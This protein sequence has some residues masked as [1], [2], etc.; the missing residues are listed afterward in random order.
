MYSCHAVM[1]L[2]AFRV[3]P[4]L[5]SVGGPHIWF[6]MYYNYFRGRLASVQY[7]YRGIALFLQLKK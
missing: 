5:S 3:Y 4:C 1:H 6:V 2:F 7:K